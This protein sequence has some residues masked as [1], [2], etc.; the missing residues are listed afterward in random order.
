M[1]AFCALYTL[2][3]VVRTESQLN[4]LSTSY[5]GVEHRTERFWSLL[6]RMETTTKMWFPNP[7][8]TQTY[9]FFDVVPSL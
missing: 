5:I 3:L 6:D 7:L 4:R 1:Q 9:H 8:P 2:P